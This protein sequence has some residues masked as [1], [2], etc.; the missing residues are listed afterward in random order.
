VPA[1]APIGG[2]QLT[3]QPSAGPRPAPAGPLN[4]PDALHLARWWHELVYGDGRRHSARDAGGGRGMNHGE[5]RPLERLGIARDQ[6]HRQHMEDRVVT[7][8]VAGALVVGVFDGHAS[9]VVAQHAAH[10]A[11]G[12]IEAG[13]GRGLG[14]SALWAEVFSQLDLDVPDAGSTAT[15]V[16]VREAHLSVAWVG[17][18]RAVLVKRDGCHV[19]TPDHRINRLDE[20]RRVVEAGAEVVPPYA[21]DPHLDRGLM[22]TRALGDRAL[23][24]IGIVAEPEVATVTLDRD[25]VGFIVGTDGLW[26]V[27]GNEEV[28]EVCRRHAPETAAQRLVGLVARRNGSD[29][30]TVVVATL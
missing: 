13:L 20:R 17:D 1:G 6:R 3:D 19:L 21:F 5:E 2:D 9:P 29:N 27:A 28:A 16:L 18:S 24:G 26:D 8:R 12:C 25:D 23:R 10:L 4:R 15:L 30:V 22:V 11:L 7:G 14:E